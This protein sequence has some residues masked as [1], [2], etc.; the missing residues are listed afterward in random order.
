MKKRELEKMQHLQA[1]NKMMQLAAKDTPTIEKRCYGPISVYKH[2]IYMRCIV[3]DNILKTAFSLA[4]HMRTGSRNPAYELYI[5]Y[6]KRAFITY[7]CRCEKWTT[8]Q[9]Y[10]IS[11]P[12]HVEW[13]S[14]KW[15]SKRDDVLVKKHL[16][17]DKGGYD[18]LVKCQSQIRY[19][20]LLRRH[21]KET[22]PWDADLLQVPKD[23]PKDWECW[24]SK[25]GIQDNYI[26][27]NYKKNGAKTGYCT[28]CDKDV[29]IMEQR[30]ATARTATRMCR[31]S[32][33]IITRKGNVHAAAIKS[34]IKL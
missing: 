28:Y 27:Y 11:W 16:G 8:S 5:D 25:V 14:G 2:G 9:L 20:E 29:P 13:Q 23:L 34:L 31:L 22:D 7:D 3:Q 15:I 24:V 32:T 4:E 6:E 18:G 19:E 21:K 12:G 17:V 26:Y 30:Q 1:T 33:L 10:N